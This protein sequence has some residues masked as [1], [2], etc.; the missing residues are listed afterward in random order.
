MRMS[1]PHL[2]FLLPAVAALA[3]VAVI[4]AIALGG[5]V[6]G[7]PAARSATPAAHDQ[8]AGHD[9]AAGDPAHTKPDFIR[10]LAVYTGTQEPAPSPH[11]V[12][13]QALLIA[14][15]LPK[16]AT[17]A[18]VLTDEDC[19]PDQHGVSHCRNQLRLAGGRTIT[20]RHPHRMMDVPCMTPGEDVRVDRGVDA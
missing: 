12:H 1:R 6:S 17:T 5:S 11:A 16:G 9:H 18:T 15:T 2:K 7:Q 4:I 14:G 8:H 20:V 10:R 19:A 3:A 13:M